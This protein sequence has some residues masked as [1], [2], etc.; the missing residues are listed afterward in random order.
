MSVIIGTN[1]SSTF[2]MCSH[3]EVSELELNYEVF[4]TVPGPIVEEYAI[5]KF[6]RPQ[7]YFCE[8]YPI[9]LMRALLSSM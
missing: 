5:E 9:Q 6:Y 3:A 1:A 4:F 2:Q 8:I 7:A